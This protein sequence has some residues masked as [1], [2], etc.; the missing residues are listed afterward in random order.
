MPDS[1]GADG[2]DIHA[3]AARLGAEVV[4]RGL[5]ARLLGGLAV[6]L[7]CPSVHEA[8]YARSY[9]DMDFAV[10]SA[11][12]RRFKEFLEEQG[13]VG[14]HFFNGLHGESRLYY[15]QRDGLWSIDVVINELAMSHRL[16]LRQRLG[17][18]AATIPLADLLLAK[19]QIWEINRKDVGDAMCLLADHPLVEDDADLEGISLPRLRSV[20]GADWGFCHTVERNLGKVEALY[21]EEAVPGA[22][23]QV[24]DQLEQLRRTIASAPKSMAWRMRSRVG[25]RVRWYETPEEVG[26]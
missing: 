23:L 6:W 11:A 17:Q 10:E 5:P 20:L 9:N 8:P 15:A 7:R 4:G 14:D 1:E 21:G 16:D 19:L 2:A 26:H 18:A 25:E 13:Y 3:E 22:S 12:S 24:S